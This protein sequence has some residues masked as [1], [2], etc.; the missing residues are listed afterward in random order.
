M[1][2]GNQI[3]HVLCDWLYRINRN[4]RPGVWGFLPTRN[5]RHNS[6]LQRSYSV[7]VMP[8]SRTFND[9]LPRFP[10]SSSLPKLRQPVQRCCSMSGIHA[11]ARLL[12]TP[13]RIQCSTVGERKYMWP[14][15]SLG[16]S[17]PRSILIALVSLLPKSRK[18]SDKSYRC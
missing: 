4:G 8:D 5:G 16:T 18:M 10:K 6:G 9:R 3:N 7:L 14:A 17:I 12:T 2:V 11:K 1:P 13:N 15:W